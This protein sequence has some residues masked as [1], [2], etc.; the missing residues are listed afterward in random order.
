VDDGVEFAKDLAKLGVEVVLDA[1]VG[2]EWGGRDLPGMPWAMRDHL[3]PISSCSWTSR[4]SSSALHSILAVS[5]LMWFSYL[6]APMPT[7]T[8]IVS[9]SSEAARVPKPSASPPG[10]SF[11]PPHPRTA[12]VAS[13]PTPTTKSF[14]RLKSLNANPGNNPHGL[15]TSSQQ[16]LPS[17]PAIVHIFV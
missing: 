4:T 14:S 7:V 5:W 6:N 15:N 9:H 13:R 8:G 16:F 11:A 10:S 3:L 12:A 17:R 1:V 2:P